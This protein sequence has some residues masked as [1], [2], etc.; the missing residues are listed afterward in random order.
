M[1][2]AYVGNFEP[3]HSTESDLRLALLN[4]GHAVS[5]MQEQN[6]DWQTLPKAVDGHDLLLWTR[7]GSLDKSDVDTQRRALRR[8]RLSMPVVGYHLDLFWG[9]TARSDRERWV[10][11]LP[12]FQDTDLIFSTDDGHNAEWADAGVEH[13]WMPPGVG[14][15]HVETVGVFNAKYKTQIGFVGSWR[16]Y[17]PEWL[18]RKQLVQWVQQHYRHRLTIWEGGIRGQ[19]LADLYT[20]AQILIGDSCMVGPGPYWSDRIPETL[21]RGGFL[22]HP[23]T[24]GL[25]DAF[26]EGTLVTWP[27][28]DFK[29]LRYLIDYYLDHPADRDV[30]AEAGRRHVAE[31]R[32]YELRMEQMIGRLKD[33]GLL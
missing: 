30:I 31:H 22:L 10:R 5:P 23:E 15:R 33:R 14:Q 29:E 1:K 17:H 24:A 18:H 4:N 11:E 28:G 16:E 20:T 25:R 32:T 13:V 9:L 27:L 12:Y 6:V 7:T 2:V 21:G 8:I 26:P 19:D 3:P